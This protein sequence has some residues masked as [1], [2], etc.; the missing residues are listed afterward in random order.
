MHKRTP[1]R[2][3]TGPATRSIP[4]RRRPYPAYPVSAGTSADDREALAPDQIPL[5]DAAEF[6]LPSDA[7]AAE[8][9]GVGQREL[10]DEIREEERQ[11][12]PD[13]QADDERGGL[14]AL[15]EEFDRRIAGGS[16]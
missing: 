7:E 15:A 1:P 14:A 8:A 16:R 11:R 5:A 3:A 4:A 13:A 12:H 6:A 9:L 10:S 2:S